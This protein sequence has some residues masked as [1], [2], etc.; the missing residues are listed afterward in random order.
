MTDADRNLY[1]LICD[2]NGNLPEYPT[3]LKKILL[4]YQDFDFNA[5]TAADCI[6]VL[7]TTQ[8]QVIL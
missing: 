6:T 8:K 2:N 5:Q 1:Q 7:N 4:K 3:E